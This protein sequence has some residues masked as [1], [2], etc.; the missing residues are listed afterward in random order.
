M[1]SVGVR[2]VQRAIEILELLVRRRRLSVTEIA[3]EMEIPKASAYQIVSTLVEKRI[4][5]KAGSNSQYSLGPN[6]FTLGSYARMNF[7]VVRVAAPHLQSLNESV[8]ETI[9]LTVLRDDE[10]LYVDCF[11]STKRL[12]THSSIGEIGELHCTAVGKAVLAF[13]SDDERRRLL[14]GKKLKRFT[15]NTIVNQ[16]E[17]LR[18]LDAVVQTGYSVDAMEHEEDVRCLGA[19]IRNHEGLVIASVSVSGPSGRISPDK[20]SL[21]SRAL[22]K[23]A[24]DISRELGYREGTTLSE[25]TEND[26]TG[27]R[28]IG[29]GEI[30]K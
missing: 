21:L 6:L 7:D 8:D 9:H 30:R 22:L 18:E 28:Q 17:L 15:R 29:K 1:K 23:T 20:Y 2:S 5:T 14:T 4:L 16:T 10:L 24:D 25:A 11:E 27:D 19:P 12:R 13:Q 3:A 26:R